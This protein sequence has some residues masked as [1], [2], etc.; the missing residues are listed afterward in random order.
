MILPYKGRFPT[1]GK[2][3]FIAPTA[4]IIG[5]VVIEDEASIWFGAVV[6]ADLDRI[7][8]GAKSNVQD[9]CTLHV[10][11]DHPLR[12]GS[13][14][15]IGHNAV[16]HGCTIEDQVLI[17]MNAT[18]LNDAV[19]RTGS[20]VGAGAVISEGMA[21]GPLQLAVGVPAKIKK[22]YEAAMA[23]HNAADAAIYVGLSSAYRDNERARDAK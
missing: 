17:G 15:T 13:E 20:V 16:I 22:N 18:I 4:V 3:V 21:I 14:V 10:D 9:N 19:I 23:T 5:D 12:I 1:V 8:I 11:K 2:N 7:T 6:R